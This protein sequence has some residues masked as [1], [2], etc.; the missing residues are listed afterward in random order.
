MD[1]FPPRTMRNSW[2]KRVGTEE[3]P[4]AAVTI[5]LTSSYI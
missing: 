4:I 1:C 5:Q 3:L 2:Q